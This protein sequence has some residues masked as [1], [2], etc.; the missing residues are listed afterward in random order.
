MCMSLAGFH[1]HGKFIIWERED[2]T[3]QRLCKICR[4]G[5]MFR[6]MAIVLATGVMQKCKKLD[7]LRIRPC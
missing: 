3:M 6:V 7:H 4:T 5:T 1:Q 2:R